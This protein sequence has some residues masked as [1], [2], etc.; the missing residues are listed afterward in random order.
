M[1]MKKTCYG[2]NKKLEDL[3]TYNLFACVY[4]VHFSLFETWFL[5][6]QI[7]QRW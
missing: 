2:L 3:Q 6:F 7:N 4:L 5:V 1:Y